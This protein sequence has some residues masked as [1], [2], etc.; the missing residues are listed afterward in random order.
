MRE[1]YLNLSKFHHHFLFFVFFASLLVT[2]MILNTSPYFL[3]KILTNIPDSPGKQNTNFRDICGRND[4]N[5]FRSNFFALSLARDSRVGWADMYMSI[6]FEF[7]CGNRRVRPKSNKFHQYFSFEKRQ[8]QT[9]YVCL[10]VYVHVD[11][12]RKSSLILN[13]KFHFS[14]AFVAD[15]SNKFC[16]SLRITTTMNEWITKQTI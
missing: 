14:E 4:K 5:K 10:F 11:G 2:C 1:S 7:V 3:D 12:C 13:E 6:W 9:M 15:K 16:I 8:T